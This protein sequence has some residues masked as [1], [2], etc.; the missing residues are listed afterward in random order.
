MYHNCEILMQV[1]VVMV[2]RCNQEYFMGIHSRLPKHKV[3][4]SDLIYTSACAHKSPTV[5][6]PRPHWYNT[7]SLHSSPGT[8]LATPWCFV[9]QMTSDMFK[10]DQLHYTLKIILIFG[11]LDMS[12]LC[13][14]TCDPSITVYIHP[15]YRHVAHYGQMRFYGYQPKVMYGALHNIECT[16]CIF[17]FSRPLSLG[18]S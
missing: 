2:V 11:K 17:L 13:V 16:V 3:R 10:N 15:L 12:C 7:Y 8:T 1:V 9:L 4:P 18:I 14:L 6:E 5:R